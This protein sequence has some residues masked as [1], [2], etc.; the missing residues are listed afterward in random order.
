[1]KNLRKVLLVVHDL[2]KPNLKMKLTSLFL[3]VS[4]L[5]IHA[6]GYGQGERLSLNVENASIE[7][8]FNKIETLTKYK[9][10]YN[11][12][13]INVD[14]KISV[15]ADNEKL[16]KIIYKIFKNT[17][18]SY[19]IADEQIIL[20]KV[21]KKNKI[22]N[23]SKK[24]IKINQPESQQL[25]T[26]KV[27]DKSQFPL[28]GVSILVKGT[29]QGV[30]TDFD[31]VF[32]FK[33]AKGD[34]LI[35]SHLGYLD[36]T[37]T[38]TDAS[39]YEIIMLPASIE[40][41]NVEI[42]STGYKTI[43]KERATGSF[44]KV[45]ESTLESKIDQNILSKIQGE[46]SG[47]LF[48][49]GEEGTPSI[50][51]RGQSS[52][53]VS[54]DPLIVVDG[55]PI[56][57]SIESI[58]PNDVESIT[59]LKDAA[60][61]SIW[62][63]RA[64]NGV[65]VIVTK[66]G[67][68]NEALQVSLSVST[69][70]T[71]ALDLFKLNYASSAQQV[72]FQREQLAASP[73][74][75]NQNQLFSGD[76]EFFSINQINPV[77]ETLLLQQRGDL[78]TSETENR[79]QQLAN[80]DVRNE[81]QDLLLRPKI[82][83]QYNLAVSGGSEKHSFRSS[84]LYNHNDS[85]VVNADSDQFVIN[86]SNSFDISKKLKVRNSINFSRSKTNEKNFEFASPFRIAETIGNIPL[87]SRILDDNGNYLPMVYNFVSGFKAN[88]QSSQLALD[89]GYPYA[90]T[91]NLKQ[92]V[93]NHNN[94]SRQVGLRLQTALDY[95]LFK[96]FDASINYQYE[97]SQLNNRV[98]SNENTWFT[99]NAVNNLFVKADPTT[100]TDASSPIPI[101]SILDQSYQETKAFT[102][103][104]QLKYDTQF[105][106]GKHLL[107]ALAGY[108]IKNLINQ[109]NS[110]RLYGYND[111]NLSFIQP[112]FLERYD[113]QI[114]GFER[115]RALINPGTNIF[116]RENRFISS[117]F[118]AAYTLDNK[119]SLSVS[120]R[121]DDT[122]LFGASK[123]YRNIPLYSAG[124]KWNIKN[125]FFS[126]SNTVN[127]LQLR[128]TF[129]VNG[130]VERNTNPFL[131]VRT[132]PDTNPF[133]N[134]SS[135]FVSSL[136]NPEL[137][138]EK[139]ETFNLGLDFGLLNNK[140]SGS[141]EYYNKN[142]KDLLADQGLDPTL[143][144]VNVLLNTGELQN[145]GID[146]NLSL[147]IAR[148]NNF[149][150]TTIGN[151]SFNK[152]KIVKVDE[153]SFDF[154]AYIFGD[155][156][157]VGEALGTVYT[158]NYAGLDGNGREQFLTENNEIVSGGD[159]A[160]SLDI[161]DLIKI[162]VRTPKYYGSWINEISY[163]NLSLRTL[164]SFSAGHVFVNNANSFN[165]ADAFFGR[166]AN[167]PN[168]VFDR[169][170]QRGDENSTDVPAVVSIFDDSDGS[171]SYFN[172]DKFVDDASFIRLQQLSLQYTL[173]TTAIKKLGVTNFGIGL[174]A[175]NVAVWNF[176]K[177]DVD[178]QSPNIPLPPT[179][180]LKLSINF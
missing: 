16:E 13:Y 171:S 134:H 160:S 99:R 109:E 57:G 28:V 124:L 82:W 108:E 65:I 85:E 148:T 8:V 104:F 23:T 133:F 22:E 114:F 71:P 61:A 80:T 64:A 17:N 136:P 48:T 158:F 168:D 34:I 120:T 25:I 20:K 116:F 53:N 115:R 7:T 164:T 122:D 175:D 36:R 33:A 118:N 169:W 103:R 49:V 69:A 138:L 113:V 98:L 83:N 163:K 126:E 35:F 31:G 167:V 91:Y 143:G 131:N 38:V 111:Q 52:I 2:L 132:S 86:F 117:Y 37:V 58:N 166:T 142:S 5:Q 178:P 42:L 112:N 174:Q 90:W 11:L 79:L 75:A 3:I 89:Q 74:Y 96:D 100:G 180:T 54:S 84:I 128:G 129:G 66:K 51:I 140:I 152:N 92:E 24:N 4:L 30:V 32:S 60:A 27:V 56:E 47:V 70:I 159:I 19:A 161:N 121:L 76:L 101:G 127:R 77:I 170:Q 68:R 110:D 162:G 177:W 156:V 146:A 10:L 102:A 137:R 150:F 105:N 157:V 41:D 63:I 9:F 12:N 62:G 141:I 18:I 46:A 139:T 73:F 173:P 94:V 1:M 6:N 15:Y 153:G 176:N 125:E 151:F 67:N 29:Q 44:Q 179:Y 81:I 144:A 40:L 119:Y 45:K 172:S 72:E 165:P 107:T 106:N 88:A 149:N 14:R 145:R 93:D 123:K 26:G 130:N 59:I 87:N 135:S 50:L 154:G 95:E 78:T 147:V 155:A 55:F 97:W 39:T 21:L 43:S